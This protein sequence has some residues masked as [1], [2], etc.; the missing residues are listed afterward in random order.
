MRTPPVGRWFP[1]GDWCAP[2]CTVVLDNFV[3]LVTERNFSPGLSER[4]E[5]SAAST[6]NGRKI[7][8]HK[9]NLQVDNDS[10]LSLMLSDGKYYCHMTAKNFAVLILDIPK[11]IPCISEI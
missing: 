3:H 6:T 10:L 1:A 9:L 5:L 2:L 8:N 11:C 4:V 7:S